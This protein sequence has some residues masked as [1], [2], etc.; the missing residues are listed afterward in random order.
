MELTVETSDISTDDG[1]YDIVSDFC[2]D[3]TGYSGGSS[4]DIQII[5][6]SS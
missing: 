5:G 3:H 6:Y 4:K 1:G 2:W